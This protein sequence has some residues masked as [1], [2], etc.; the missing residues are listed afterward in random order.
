[1][2][3]E[4]ANPVRETESLCGALWSGAIRLASLLATLALL[5]AACSPA[6]SGE[7]SSK[8]TA[9]APSAWTVI[10]IDRSG[11]YSFIEPG[12]EMVLQ[13]VRDAR[14][15]DTIVVRWISDN[16]YRN[17]EFALRFQAPTVAPRDCS[18]NPYDTTCRREN[19]AAQFEQQQARDSAITRVRDLRVS[20]AARTDLVGFL[21][22]AAEVLATA[23]PEA[24]RRIWMATD[25]LDNVRLFELPV[26][27]QG[28]SV[29][30]RG[31]QND[32]PTKAVA[33]RAE[34][35]QRLTNYGA[36]QIRFESA[37]V[38]R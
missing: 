6:A 32:D 21:L 14:P 23:P 5:L 29:F 2:T 26:D 1:M 38:S 11:S 34:W 18:A 31:L 37:E 22:A 17:G 12:R 8:A 3:H 28:A 36:S 13:A 33:L 10:G 4:V 7:P 35:E 19:L 16:S 15:G 30:V 24:E 25:L 20:T 9:P 27:L